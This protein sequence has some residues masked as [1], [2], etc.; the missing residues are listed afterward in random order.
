MVVIN[1][2]PVSYLQTD[3]RWKY[4]PYRVKGESSTIGGSGCGPTAAAMLIESIT[5]K[6]FD[7]VQ[8]C[9]WSIRNGYK[10]LKQGTYYSYFKPQFAA[11]GIDC[12]QLSWTSTYHKPN[13]RLHKDAFNYLQQGYYLIALMKKGL[14]TNGGHYV[15]VYGVDEKNNTVYINDPASTR[16]ER[17]RGNL[18]TFKNEVKYYWIVDGRSLNK[19][20]EEDMVDQATIDSMVQAALNKIA[21]SKKDNDSG[22]WSK[23]AREFCV[24]QGLFM[25][26]SES[27]PNFMW[28]DLMTREQCAVLLYR[29]AQKTGFADKTEA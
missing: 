10:A 13:H 27:D 16:P 6:K 9:T 3:P 11:F 20:E 5:G 25:G 1:K 26:N 15:V 28:E 17:I 2:K 29:F 19:K 24:K 21:A 18:R 4:N 23:E 7:P 22:E 14:W 12:W 8:A